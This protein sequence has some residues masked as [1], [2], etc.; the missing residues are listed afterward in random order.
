M[1]VIQGPSIL[2][3]DDDARLRVLLEKFLTSEGF[4]VYLASSAAEARSYVARQVFNAFVV[5][6]MMPGENG[7]SLLPSLTSQAPVL[8]LTAKDELDD[9]VKGFEQGADDYLTKPFEPMELAVRLRA[10]LRRG[11]SNKNK[12]FIKLGVLTFDIERGELFADSEEIYLSSTEKTLLSTLAQKPGEPFSREELA[13]RIGHRISDRTVDVQIARLRRKVRDDM[14]QP[15][16][17]RT[18]RHVGYALLYVD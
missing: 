14:S 13:Q 9:K 5:D 7:L 3:V 2:V 10:L 16:I 15:K 12:A 18:I 11:K 4:R 8:M 1:S 17:I 6:I